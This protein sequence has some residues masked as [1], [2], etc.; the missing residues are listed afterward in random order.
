VWYAEPEIGAAWGA[1]GTIFTGIAVAHTLYAPREVVLW[2]WRRILLL[3]V[4]IALAVGSQYSLFVIVLL[5][6]P[7]MLY[8][9]P[10][11]Q[12]AAVAIWLAACGVA[13][14]LLFAG[15]G[16]RPA[17]IVDAA[18]RAHWMDW[19]ARALTLPDALGRVL[20]QLGANSPALVLMLPV[21]LIAYV[22]WPRARYFGNTAPLLVALICFGLGWA[23]PHY[24]GLGFQL[25]ALPFFFV[26]IAGVFADL[27]ETKQRVL[28]LA[29]LFGLLSAYAVLSLSQLAQATSLR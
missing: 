27:L 17:A 13:A 11:R 2:N 24:P 3:G 9:A 20:V 14:G 29:S 18:S 21:A 1:F 16:F 19:T 4:S 5:A 15:Y 12:R 22:A 23:S 25:V 10:A 26:F 7:F 28:V 8:L 6:L